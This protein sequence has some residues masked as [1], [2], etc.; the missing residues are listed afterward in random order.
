[1]RRIRLLVLL[2]FVSLAGLCSS[3]QTSLPRRIISLSPNVT[4]ILYGVGAFDRVVAVSD[5]CTYPPAVKNLPRIGGW[6]NSSVER[7]AAFRPDL[8]ILVD[9]QAPFLEDKLQKLGLRTL[10]TPSRSLNDV[11]ATME[12][13]GRATGH[14][15][16]AADLVRST[17]AALD[18]VRNTTRKLPR[19]SVLFVVD[20]TPGTLR[21]LYVATEGGF[22][23]ELVAIGGGK[24]IAAPAKSGYGRISKEAVLTLNPEIIIDMVHGS[25]GKFGERPEMV[26]QDL[27][28]L[29]AVRERRIY[30]VREEFLPHASQFVADTAKLLARLIHP[31]AFQGGVK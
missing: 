17:R 2:I 12:E 6:Q 28:E 7:I 9:A 10:V 19:R 20:R 5:Y 16:Q 18:E 14:E 11:F 24:S 25:K 15:A 29:Q 13:I 4:E 31:E 1:M 21:D 30:P 3:A 8:V 27:P 22:L 23:E 26:W